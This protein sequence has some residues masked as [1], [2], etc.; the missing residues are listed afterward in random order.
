MRNLVVG[1]GLFIV[2]SGF[3][4]CET[5]EPHKPG[6]KC[7]QSDPCAS[8]L[9]CGKDGTCK[10]Q[11]P[12]YLYVTD[13]IAR[14]MSFEIDYVQG[15]L[16][17]QPAIDLLLGRLNDL[18]QSGHV[19]KPDGFEYIMDDTIPA[20]ADPNHAYTFEEL[21]SI[22]T[23]NKNTRSSGRYASAYILYV[24]GHS[25]DD[26]GSSKVLGF[27]YGGDKIVVFK[28]TIMSVC[29]G[30]LFSS[31]VCKVTEGAVLTH[32]F[33]HLMGLVNNGL[34][35]HTAHQDAAHGGHDVNDQCLM[36]WAIETDSGV[37]LILSRVLGGDSSIPRFD[38]QCMQDMLDA[39]NA[40]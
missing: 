13:K 37:S 2:L 36:Y 12:P 6:A 7:G 40:D 5:C 31:E 29:S 34:S 17:S 9:Y 22:V 16:P 14:K 25:A 35:M 4:E 26:N 27:A 19:K 15:Q 28:N 18:H 1:M 20:H 8:G 23:N 11:T 30:G 33:G 39:Q 24:D 38:E 10:T 21:N 32:E 3:G